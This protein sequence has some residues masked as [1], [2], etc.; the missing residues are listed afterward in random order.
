MRQILRSNAAPA[1]TNEVL[2]RYTNKNT[3]YAADDLSAC[4]CSPTIQAQTLACPENKSGSITQRRNGACTTSACPTRQWTSWVTTSNTCSTNAKPIPPVSVI[5]PGT[6]CIPE[7]EQRVANCPSGQIGFVIESRTKTCPSQQWGSWITA[8]QSCAAPAPASTPCTYD[9]RTDKEVRTTS[10]EAGQGGTITQERYRSCNAESW[11]DWKT[12]NNTCSA[13]C[14]TTGTCCTPGRMQ[15]ATSV[16][17]PINT[18]GQRNGIEEQF[19]RC[20]SATTTPVWSGI[21]TVKG[22]SVTGSCNA[23]PANTVEVL[24]RSEPRSGSCA[25]GTYGTQRWEALFTQNCADHIRLQC[26]RQSDIAGPQ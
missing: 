9:P 10:C 23:C 7:T 24:N 4:E 18:Y 26:I 20:A 3:S 12:L 16:A 15:R 2:F 11:S 19:S 5:A 13:S 17:C 6:A 8:T 1:Q 22:S 25:T 14:V 21:W